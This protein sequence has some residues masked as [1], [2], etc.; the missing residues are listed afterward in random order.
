MHIKPHITCFATLALLV[1][2]T[3]VLADVWPMLG[4][5]PQHTG[6]ST[7]QGPSRGGE[8]RFVFWL[9]VPDGPDGPD[10]CKFSAFTASQIV[11]LRFAPT[12]L[13][14]KLDVLHHRW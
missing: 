6:Q 8:I 13:Q 2:A 3:G 14:H 1:A 12:F 4:G 10:P 11:S 5:N 7:L 9:W